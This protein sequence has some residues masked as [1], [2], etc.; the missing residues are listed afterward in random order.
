MSLVELIEEWLLVLLKIPIPHFCT[1]KS[2]KKHMLIVGENHSQ[3]TFSPRILHLSSSRDGATT[4][5][6]IYAGR[7]GVSPESGL[8]LFV[9]LSF[10]NNFLSTNDYILF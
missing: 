8:D 2:F 4:V 7:E 10:H 9:L 3:V 1:A 6:I 5:D